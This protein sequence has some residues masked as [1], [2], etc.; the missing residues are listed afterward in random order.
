MPADLSLQ[1]ERRMS[2]AAWGPPGGVPLTSSP[3]PSVA[4]EGGE[5]AVECRRGVEGGVAGVAHSAVAPWLVLEW[6]AFFSSSLCIPEAVVQNG[7]S[8]Q[9]SRPQAGCV[10]P[11]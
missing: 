9:G 8:G 10:G 2:R 4:E 11:S 5:L 6:L 7:W 3:A 1:V